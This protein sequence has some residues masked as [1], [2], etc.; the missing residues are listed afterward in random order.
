MA[1]KAKS[2]P[3]ILELIEL[4]GKSL[5]PYHND[6]IVE[7]S[8][9]S[10]GRHQ[11]WV[12][13][14]GLTIG[15]IPEREFATESEKLKPGDRVLAYVLEFE[16]EEGHVV[17]SLRRAE[18]ERFLSTLKEKFESKEALSAKV[19]DAN[20]GGLM[21]ESHGITGFLPVSQLLPENYPRVPGG[22][23]SEILD[24][25]KGFV[26]KV[27]TVRIIAYE[28]GANKLIFS[29][30]AVLSHEQEE[31]LQNF[32]KG[33]K[34]NVAVTGVADFG[35]FV[36]LE[37]EKLEGLIHISE[38]SW[39]RVNN[40]KEKFGVGERLEAMVLS[41]NN[42]RVSLSLKRLQPDPWVEATKGLK[43]GEKLEGS[44]SRITPFGAFIAISTGI[45]GLAHISELSKE[46]VESPT[47]VLKEGEKLEFKIVSL[48]V[49]NHRLG[50]SLKALTAE[51]D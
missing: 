26:G 22:D 3:T 36:Q 10:I 30:R 44:V 2:E 16:N 34:V 37:K 24:R 18:R 1:V 12:D 6:E 47:D 43:V 17:L 35:L 33:D 40:L 27:M 19:V 45:E 46:R 7:V 32:E 41:V 39:D 29:E 21:V 49:E 9:L 20:K 28:P 13:V 23:K 50:L 14:K 8:V 38:I 42:G 15:L 5:V 51:E 48:D 25:L 31:R 4:C 11:I